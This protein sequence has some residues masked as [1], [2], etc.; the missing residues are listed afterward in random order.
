MKKLDPEEII[1]ISFGWCY[2]LKNG[3]RI[4]E[5]DDE[6][7]WAHDGEGEI[8]WDRVKNIEAIAAQ[9]PTARYLLV[10]EGAMYSQI[11]ERFATGWIEV[12]QM[13][14]FADDDSADLF[15]EELA[16]VIREKTLCFVG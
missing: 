6:A 3:D 13:L 4:W 14:G 11:Y 16:R 15:Q 2:L 12:R 8:R 10:Q 7:I 5:Q 1:N 9:D